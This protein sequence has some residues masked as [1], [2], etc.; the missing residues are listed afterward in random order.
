MADDDEE[1]AAAAAA[2]MEAV[3]LAREEADSEEG[4]A[5]RMRE[6]RLV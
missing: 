5:C 2:A 1:I 6:R 3:N 4:D